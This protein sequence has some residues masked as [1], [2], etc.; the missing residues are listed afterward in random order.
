MPL[1]HSN[2]QTSCFTKFLEGIQGFFSITLSSVMNFMD[3]INNVTLSN[4]PSN[5]TC[6]EC[7]KAMI[8][9]LNKTFPSV[10]SDL[11]PPL[12]SKC[13][14]SFVGKALSYASTKTQRT[15]FLGS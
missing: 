1:Y 10:V 12:A 8:I 5:L 14:T 9:E 3:L 11:T 15:D 2:T 6:T 7:N 4:L 13:D